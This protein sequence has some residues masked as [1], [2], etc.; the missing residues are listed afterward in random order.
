MKQI[1]HAALAMLAFANAAAAPP[2]AYTSAVEVRV[3]NVRDARGRIHVEL[4]P[5]P[6]FLGDCTLVSETPAHAGTTTVTVI[7]VPPGVYAAQV[8]HDENMNGKVDRG[9]F[10]IPREGVGFSNDAKLYRKGP[11]FDEAQFRVARPVE[12]IALRLRHFF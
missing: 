6:L 9:L 2:N 3:S 7:N 1:V 5:Q 12:R 10:G 4:C 8:Y 11:H